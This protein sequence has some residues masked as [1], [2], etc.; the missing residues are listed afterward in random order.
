LSDQRPLLLI[1][2]FDFLFKFHPLGLTVHVLVI[3]HAFHAIHLVQ[4]FPILHVI[5]SLLSKLQLFQEV[6]LQ[7]ARV[8]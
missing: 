5:T 4:D 8:V 1:H 3:A 6:I 2:L 7:F